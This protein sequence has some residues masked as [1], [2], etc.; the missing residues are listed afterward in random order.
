MARSTDEGIQAEIMALADGVAEVA[1]QVAGAAV[2][3]TE[4]VRLTQRE[5]CVASD[6]FA[7][8]PNSIQAVATIAEVLSTKTHDTGQHA[9]RSAS[10]AAR[11]TA[12][13]SR[14][15]TQIESLAQAVER[16]GGVVRLISDIANQTNILALNA[17]IEA[18]RA[19]EFGR[20][21]AVVANEVK[22]LASQTAKATTDIVAQI[23]EIKGAAARAVDGIGTVAG[24][25]DEMKQT[26]DAIVSAIDEQ[27]S[28]T[29]DISRNAEAVAHTTTDVGESIDKVIGT[30]IE[31]EQ[32]VGSLQEN[33]ESLAERSAALNRAVKEF[34]QGACRDAA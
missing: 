1:E 26:S 6:G 19:G 22:S 24:T 23:S 32:V 20:G 5:A 12:E 13:A 25:I 18:A 30:S 15:S 14:T 4:N 27:T 31:T 34:L 8:A 10:T 7:D 21:F 3:T 17:T 11:A 33:A 28:A 16:M 2:R 9:S 29:E